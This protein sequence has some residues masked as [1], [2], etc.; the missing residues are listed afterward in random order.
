M[1][2]KAL[3]S[4]FQKEAQPATRASSGMVAPEPRPPFPD[5]GSAAR[6]TLYVEGWCSDSRKAERLCVERG[7]PTHREALDGRHADKVA[8]FKANGWRTL[9]MVFV[10]G[11]FL[12]GLAALQKLEKLP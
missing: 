6:V 10:D 3:S 11:R 12:G 8:L 9:P 4:L 5:A 1:L 2:R 7:W